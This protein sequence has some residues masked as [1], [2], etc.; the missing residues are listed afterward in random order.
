MP[1]TCYF[2][3]P[4]AHFQLENFVETPIERPSK[5]GTPGQNSF[6][7][8]FWSKWPSVSIL[9]GRPSWS[10]QKFLVKLYVEL[11]IHS[12]EVLVLL[13]SQSLSSEADHQ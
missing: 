4:A 5:M 7:Q 9:V 8:L 12:L 1:A 6:L 11:L 10:L 3:C 13:G 2:S